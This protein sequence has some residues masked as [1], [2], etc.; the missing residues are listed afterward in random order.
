MR[1]SISASRLTS[2]RPTTRNVNSVPRQAAWGMRWS[3]CIEERAQDGQVGKNSGII[4]NARCTQRGDQDLFFEPCASEV[5]HLRFGGTQAVD[6][7]LIAPNI[8]GIVRN[9]LAGCDRGE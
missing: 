3:R 7:I 2:K 6:H 4:T 5:Q 1:E 9:N 8:D